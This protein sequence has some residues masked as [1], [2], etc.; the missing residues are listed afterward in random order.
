[1]GGIKHIVYLMILVKCI[2]CSPNTEDIN[3]TVEVLT[4]FSELEAWMDDRLDQTVVVN[5][6]A[7]SCPPCVKEMPHFKALEK[8]Y[9]DVKVLLVS[10]DSPKSL[11]TRVYPFIEKHGI[12][13]EVVVLGDTNY[14]AWTDK[15]DSS[16]YGALPATLVVQNDR[17]KFRFGAYASVEEI[18]ADIAQIASVDKEE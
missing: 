5:F 1:M 14:S 16:W 18:V 2:A 13:P 10:L 9:P 15:I 3:D 12:S 11:D 17:R 6:W 7:T 8:D 4:T